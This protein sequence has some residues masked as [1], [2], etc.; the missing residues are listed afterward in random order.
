MTPSVVIDDI[1]NASSSSPHDQIFSNPRKS[2]RF[3]VLTIL[4]LDAFGD[5]PLA[6]PV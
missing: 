6:S 1:Q 2:R 3:L 5:Q 4:P